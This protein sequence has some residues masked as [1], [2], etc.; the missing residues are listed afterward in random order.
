VSPKVK[1]KKLSFVKRFGNGQLLKSVLLPKNYK[2]GYCIW[3]FSIAVSKSTRAIND[4]NSCKKNKR[5]AKLK[6]SLPGAVGSRSLIEA[7]RITRR[8]FEYIPKGDAIAFQCT[9]S[10][11]QKQLRVFKKWLIGRENLPWEYLEDLNIFFLYK[12]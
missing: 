7:A 3:N 4:W 11:P 2:N 6:N 8:C 12:N 1:R 10:L 5:A 9:S